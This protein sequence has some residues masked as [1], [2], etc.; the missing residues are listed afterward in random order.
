MGF[1][2]PCSLS[3]QNTCIL[4]VSTDLFAI[5]QSPKLTSQFQLKQIVSEGKLKGHLGGS[6]HGLTGCYRSNNWVSLTLKC[7]L[8]IPSFFL[9]PYPHGVIEYQCL[10][11]TEQ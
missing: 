9:H 1:L 11:E 3:T 5:E 2:S 8:P 7:S 10:P 6:Y 4:V